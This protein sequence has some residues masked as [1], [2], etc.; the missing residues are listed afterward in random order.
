MR[1][2]SVPRQRPPTTHL[3]RSPV[4]L[5]AF[6]RANVVAR[7]AD[8]AAGADQQAW[9]SEANCRGVKT[10]I[11][12]PSYSGLYASDPA[13]Q[14]CARCCVRAECLADALVRRETNGIWGGT[15]ERM[16]RVLR[17]E[18]RR[19]LAQA[20]AAMQTIKMDAAV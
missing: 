18:L 19:E 9:R 8:L 3:P 4:V 2:P 11:F 5:S 10:N 12:Y 17:R 20:R 15:T 7:L 6:D 1:A 13:L 16:R 14:I